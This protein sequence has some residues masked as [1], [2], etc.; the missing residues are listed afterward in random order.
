VD[1]IRGAL[2]ARGGGKNSAVVVLQDFQPVLDVGSVF[3]AGLGGEFKVGS[4]EGASQFGNEFFHGISIRPEAVP[5]EIA[6]KP[7][8]G[9]SP[10]RRFMGKR[11]VIRL[12]AAEGLE[13]S[14]KPAMLI[15]SWI[16][17]FAGGGPGVR[18]AE[19]R[20]LILPIFCED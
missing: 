15:C 7:G 8:L 19:N 6:V 10:V 3:L 20:P 11:A 14:G 5:A 2:R 17:G 9:G 12:G 1:E 4:E 18:H 16:T 13:V